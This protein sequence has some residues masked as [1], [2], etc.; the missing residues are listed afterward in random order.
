MKIAIIGTGIAGNVA[1]YHLCKEHEVT[2]YEAGE[3]VGGHSHTHD[4]EWHGQNYA[5]DTGFIVFN[6]K[7][8][9]QFTR[10]LQEL[11]VAVRPSNMSF[12]VKCERSGLEYNG[13]NL[14]SLFAQRRN[15]FRPSFYRMIRD[16]LRFN[17]EATALIE[18]DAANMS[19]GEFLH[20]AGYGREFIDQY[21][22]PMGAAIW[23]ADPQLMAQFPAGFFIRFFHNHGLLSVNDRPQWHVIRGGS[24]EYV[25]KLTAPFAHRIRTRAA[26]QEISR[27]ATHVSIKVRGEEAEHFDQVFI[28]TH[29]DQALRMLTD[30]T[31]SEREILSALPYQHN[32]AV[33]HTDASIL[34]RRR[35]A[36]AA[37][38]YHLLPRE[39]GRVPVTYNMNILQG[40]DAPVQF[41]VTLN[42]GSAIDPE[43][44][45]KQISYHHPIF[46]PEGIAAQQRQHEI[47]GVN[48]TYYCGAYWRYGFHED[49]VIS[50]LAALDHF[51]EQSHAQLSLSRTA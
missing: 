6:Y 31:R 39:Q 27:H 15:L 32:T 44:I 30:A 7:T 24:R 16:I 47:N 33:L 45:I 41:C 38:N 36:W 28:A 5:V 1:A 29:S 2:V 51:Q 3:H 20:T 9:P 40:L 13:N 48:R 23:S 21:L 22:V 4:I 26:V 10:L 11:D 8:Y 42:N 19:L 43:R 17:R 14:N 18:A 34:P 46:T 50:A 12:S 35:L 37:W 49:G 25:R